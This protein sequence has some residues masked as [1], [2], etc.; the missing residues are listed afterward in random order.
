M[1]N[2][3]G[4]LKMDLQGGHTTGIISRGAVLDV[5]AQEPKR[6]GIPIRSLVRLKPWVPGQGSV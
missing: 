6:N 1:F 4:G 2:F 3:P 5:G